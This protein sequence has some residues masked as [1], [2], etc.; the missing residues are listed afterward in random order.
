M[1]FWDTHAHIY[2]LDDADSVLKDMQK[3]DVVGC[4][5]PAVDLA[6]SLQSIQLARK[7]KNIVGACIGLHP[8]ADI[9]PW[10]DFEDLAREH[11]DI[12]YA[13]GETGLDYYRNDISKDIQKKRLLNHIDLARTL[14]LPLIIHGRESLDDL[15]DILASTAD[16]IKIILHSFTDSLQS[17]HRALD[18]GYY[19]S[20]SGIVTFKNTQALRDV[21]HSVPLERILIET[22]SPYLSPEPYRGRENAPKN[23]VEI[24]KMLAVIKQLPLED[25]AIRL[26][27]NTRS[28]FTRIA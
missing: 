17:A 9:E 1:I 22:D 13:V 18:L 19:I 10:K 28:V 11:K 8:N 2:M 16:G 23:V 4:I 15:L 14:D 5:C 25:V 26:L 21:M 3:A 6:S 7:Y 24:A 20:F 12:L 27:L